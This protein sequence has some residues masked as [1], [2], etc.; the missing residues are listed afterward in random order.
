MGFYSEL[1]DFG[2]AYR[3]KYKNLAIANL[4]HAFTRSAFTH[5]YR[6]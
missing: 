6:K 3:K 2:N 4:S 5:E 1:D